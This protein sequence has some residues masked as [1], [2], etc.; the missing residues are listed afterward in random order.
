MTRLPN[1]LQPAWPLVKRLHRLSTLVSG[2]VFRPLSRLRG[3]RALPRRA[4]L[5]AAETAAR[6]PDAVRLHAAAAGELIRRPQAQGTPEAHWVFDKARVFDV[7]AR[8][9]LEID[10]GVVV[11]DYGANVTPDGTLDFETSEYFGI[12]G[13][14]EHPIFL[15]RGLPPVE[16]V[17]GTLV[18]LATRGGSGNYYH[19]LLDVLPRF[20][21]FEE[22]MPGRRADALYVPNGAAWQRDLLELVG[23]GD[24]PVIETRKDR[25]VRADHL[26]VPSLP[27]PLEVAPRAT[28]EWLRSRLVPHDVTDKPKRIY[29]TRGSARNTRRIVQEEALM[30]LLEERGFVRIEPGGMS[31]RDQIDHYA[32]AEVVVA[33]HGAALT[34]LVFARPGVKILEIFPAS[35]VNSCFWAISDSVPDA[36]YTYLIAGNADA[37]G[38]GSPM[39]RI[40]ADIDVDP[41]AVAAAVDRLIDT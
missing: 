2:W 34:N 31:V 14:R 12:S 1:T 6:E 15:R 9:S 39:N 20:G 18:A 38:R 3:A 11:G 37:Y 32:A 5:T 40:Q 4:T 24:H 8:F 23:L 41:E 17:D 22:T 26:V 21:V 36:R 35:Y 33:P 25:A 19:F 16:H 27:N 30:A 10:D 7:P 13:W 29:I 28:V